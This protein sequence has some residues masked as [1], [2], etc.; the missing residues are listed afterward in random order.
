MAAGH[1]YLF[2]CNFLAKKQSLHLHKILTPNWFGPIH[3]SYL[4]KSP[5]DFTQ[6]GTHKKRNYFLPQF[7][8]P[9]IVCC[10]PFHCEC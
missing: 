3:L 9:I 5:S 2:D 6:N 7:L 8:R 1:M 10:D 4:L